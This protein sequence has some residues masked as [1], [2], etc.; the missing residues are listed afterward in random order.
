[1]LNSC[2]FSETNSAFI[3]KNVIWLD[4]HSQAVDCVVPWFPRWNLSSIILL[5]WTFGHISNLMT[6]KESVLE[7]LL[8]WK[9]KIIEVAVSAGWCLLRHFYCYKLEYYKNSR[10]CIAYYC[11]NRY[12]PA[13]LFFIMWLLSGKCACIKTCLL[14]NVQSWKFGEIFL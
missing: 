6:T 14:W 10:L 3:S 4:A 5:T 9:K 7:R 8:I 11:V 2:N 13:F 12:A 1:L